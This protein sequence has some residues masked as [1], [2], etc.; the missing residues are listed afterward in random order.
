LLGTKALDRAIAK[1]FFGDPMR[2]QRD[3]L[4]DAAHAILEA[5]DLPP[6]D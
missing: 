3:L 1:A 6:I 5:R 4:G 2:M